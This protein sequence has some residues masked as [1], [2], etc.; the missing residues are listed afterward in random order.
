MQKLIKYLKTRENKTSYVLSGSSPYG[1]DCSGMVVW[2]YKHFGITL[3]HSADAQGK[4]G[5]RVSLG[6][7]KVGD[8]AV[9]AYPKRTDFYHS[10]VVYKITTDKN[11]KREILIIN[12]NAYTGTT[13]I[14]PLSD[15]KKSQIRFVRLVPTV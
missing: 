15:Y 6:E 1:W 11:G 14:Q 10:S 12:A 5:E 4:M 8:I 3:P 2:L 7:V 9:Y 13:T